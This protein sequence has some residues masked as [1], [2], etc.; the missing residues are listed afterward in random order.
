MT[1]YAA[2]TPRQA[3]GV[4]PSASSEEVPMDMQEQKKQ[5][6][7]LFR[8]MLEREQKPAAAGPVLGAPAASQG[9]PQ[10]TQPHPYYIVPGSAVLQG[11]FAQAS[12]MA[13]FQSIV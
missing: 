6:E 7:A 13:G 4:G 12:R 9:L 2:T 8:T 10:I 11:E 5:S 1:I 3:T